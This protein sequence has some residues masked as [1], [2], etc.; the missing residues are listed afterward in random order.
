MAATQKAGSGLPDLSICQEKSEVWIF[1]MN[2]FNCQ[3][4]VRAEQNIPAGDQCMNSG[5]VHLP[6]GL[7]AHSELVSF[8]LSLLCFLLAL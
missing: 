8:L 3:Q 7:W 2:L 5:D 1:Y 4:L 6:A